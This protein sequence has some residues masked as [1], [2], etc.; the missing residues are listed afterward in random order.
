[1]SVKTTGAE[2]KRF[3]NDTEFW[4]E[5]ADYYHEDEVIVVNGVEPKDF[6]TVN[7]EDLAGNDQVTLSGGCVYNA[8]GE[9]SFETYFKR[10]R[11]KQ[12][13][14]TLIVEAPKERAEEIAE[15]I[16]NAGAKVIV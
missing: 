4:P 3:Y 11:K 16:R 10:W 13:T 5:E 8:P 12:A 2:L 9:P 14:A 7:I 1:M 6:E 15:L